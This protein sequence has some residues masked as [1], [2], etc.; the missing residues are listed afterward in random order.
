MLKIAVISDTHLGFAYGTL[1]GKDAF[2]NCK[3]AFQKVLDAKADLIL[4]PGD[5]FHEKIPRQE[6]LGETIELFSS[7]K[8]HFKS[9]KL[10]T[11]KTKD[12]ITKNKT[13]PPIITI[14]GTHE[15]RH[16]DSTN[17]V[18]LLEKAGLVYNLHAESIQ[19][20]L[21][22]D[23]VGIHGLSGVPET[24]AKQSLSVWNPEPFK[25]CPNVLMLHQNF[26]ELIPEL[27]TD[28]MELSD[29]PKGFDLF[30]LGHVHW[31]ME[32]NHPETNKKLKKKKG[33]TFYQ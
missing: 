19:I 14:Y 20:E 26:K 25:N 3:Q 2:D 17:P 23:R 1:R 4:I 9:P 6:V 8:K 5:I 21:K 33:F 24:Y 22:G 12:G 27:E 13:I 30:L 18:H 31:N 11:S 28:Y 10:I 29:L 16:S 15:R 32:F 7:I